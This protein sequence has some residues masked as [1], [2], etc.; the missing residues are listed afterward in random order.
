MDSPL[1]VRMAEA[2]AHGQR[3]IGPAHHGY[4]ALVALVGALLP[5]REL[6]GRAL[7]LASGLALIALVY[8]LARRTA[9]AG[10]ATFAGLLV[11]LHPLLAVFS[12][13][14]MTESTFLAI[15]AGAVLLLE[16]R[17]RFAG[18][19]GLGLAYTVRPEALVMAAG[20]ALLSRGGRRGALLVLSGFA[21]VAIPYVGYMSWERGEFTLSPKS[22][23]IHPPAAT[24]TEAEWRIGASAPVEPPRTLIERIR[25]AAPS[26][27][28]SYLPTLG[29]H[30]RA[31]IEVWP[32]P[33]MALSVIGLL[34]RRGPV[35]SPLLQLLVMPLLAVLA[36]LRFSQLLVPS[37]AVF[38]ADASGWL[39]RRWTRP[40]RLAMA[41]ALVL[42]VSGLFLSWRGPA[43]HIARSFDDGPMTQMRAAGQWLRG[44]GR[45]GATVMDRKA[46]VAFYAGMKHEQL[47][48]DDYDTV[49]EYARRAADYVVLEEY[50]IEKIR[51]Q[52]ATFANDSVFRANERRLRLVYGTRGAPH[53][54]VAVFEVNRDTTRIGR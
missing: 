42:A 2:M 25:W 48:N 9:S 26:M 12:G 44:H 40:P 27:L 28:R 16:D 30:A 33:L 46:Y 7:S 50:V 17:H 35:A 32:W 45:P 39:A 29:S 6:P 24:R 5:G 43:G 19:I 21:L 52:F 53:T 3:A 38:A 31:L 11:A 36:D 41:A 15:A 18:G 20:A 13:P 37:L 4:S 49:V 1:Y 51:P 47:P 14:I 8:V 10:W 54:G 22:A 34:R 23:L